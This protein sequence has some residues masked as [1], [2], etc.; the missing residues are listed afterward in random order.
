[1]SVST[2]SGVD[3]RSGG[4]FRSECV[5]ASDVGPTAAAERADNEGCGCSVSDSTGYGIQVA[6]RFR[7][8]FL[9]QLIVIVGSRTNFIGKCLNERILC[10]FE[11]NNLLNVQCV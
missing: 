8:F 2:A 6:Q 9:R 4:G 3:R 5:C 7:S 1:M 10:F 11:Q